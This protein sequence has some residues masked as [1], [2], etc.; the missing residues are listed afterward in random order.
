MPS[1]IYGILAAGRPFIAMMEENTEVAQI[2]RQDTVG[3]VVRPGGVDAL[4]GAIRE[5]VDAPERLKQMGVRA[6]RLAELRFD[7]I[8]VTSRFRR[9]VAI[10]KVGGPHHRCESLVAARIPVQM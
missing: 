7:R 10:P 8:N 5:A 2:A 4:V 6:R 9:V 1:K 3:F